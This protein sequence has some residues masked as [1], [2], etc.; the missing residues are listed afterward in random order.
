MYNQWL[1]FH[2]FCENVF[3]L[4]LSCLLCLAVMWKSIPNHLY[5][6]HVCVEGG[7][8][9]DWFS[10]CTNTL[11]PEM[12]AERGIERREGKRDLQHHWRNPNYPF[13]PFISPFFL[14]NFLNF[15]VIFCFPGGH[16]VSPLYWGLLFLLRST[17]LSLFV[18][19]FARLLFTSLLYLCSSFWQEQWFY[20]PTSPL[21][22]WVRYCSGAAF[23]WHLT[24]G[25]KTKRCR[26]KREWHTRVESLCCTQ[27][28]R[29]SL[30]AR[31]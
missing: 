15:F 29:L 27:A 17:S 12:G 2:S 5:C 13:F 11:A 22:G 10:L 31:K 21:P 14:L 20:Y 7:W 16:R 24:Q 18:L 4:G 3:S 25:T 23:T 26:R 28:W 6:Q 1:C 30:A 9:G 8:R 19:S